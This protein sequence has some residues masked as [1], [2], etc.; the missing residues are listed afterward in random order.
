MGNLNYRTVN[1]SYKNQF[2]DTFVNK[3]NVSLNSK[4]F[5]THY[6]T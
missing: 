2:K 4:I 3:K 5:G 6:L 1:K